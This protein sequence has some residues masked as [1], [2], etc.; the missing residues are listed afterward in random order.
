MI[1]NMIIQ[2]DINLKKLREITGR[3]VCMPINVNFAK[4][5]NDTGNLYL[6]G[7]AETKDYTI[8][9]I[10][11][12]KGTVLGKHHHK[13]YK[14]LIMIDGHMEIEMDGK[15]HVLKR[16]DVVRVVPLVEH[17][18]RYKEDSFLLLIT[19][20]SSDEFPPYTKTMIYDKDV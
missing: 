17:D 14:F 16:G 7:V 19:I 10:H 11:G 12:E 5:K 20:P 15:T 4:I 9:Y 6:M 18:G 8:S 13:E 1:N 3:L 2:N